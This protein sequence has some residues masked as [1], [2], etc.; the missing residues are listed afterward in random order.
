[1]K[2]IL[3]SKLLYRI[4]SLSLRRLVLLLI[5][6]IILF[7]NIY[8]YASPGNG[9]V[10]SIDSEITFGDCIYFSVVTLTTLGYGDYYPVGY[11]KALAVIEVIIG[12]TFFGILVSK[13]TAA[14]GDYILHRLYSSE[15]QKR[16]LEFDTGISQF[17]EQ[18]RNGFLIEQSREEFRSSQ[19]LLVGNENFY[20]KL[21]SLIIGMRKYIGYEVY[22]GEIFQDISRRSL[23]RVLNSS[24]NQLELINSLGKKHDLAITEGN[25]KR[26]ERIMKSYYHSRYSCES[27]PAFLSKGRQKFLDK[28]R[29][30]KVA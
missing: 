9:V 3:E 18:L 22:Y 11:G 7:A 17:T 2:I 5:A 27:T 12:V 24:R 14:K 15:V 23:F 1:M 8:Y 21:L 16:L 4:S 30:L 19:L 20:E 25:K 6:T 29:H 13:L 26:L 28:V 10:S